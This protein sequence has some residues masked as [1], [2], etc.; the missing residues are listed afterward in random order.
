MAGRGNWRPIVQLQIVNS[1]LEQLLSIR[2]KVS[3][4]HGERLLKR[5]T[6]CGNPEVLDESQSLSVKYECTSLF[7]EMVCGKDRF[8]EATG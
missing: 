8:L 6:E 2:S 1:W 7:V 3:C 5:K 4:F